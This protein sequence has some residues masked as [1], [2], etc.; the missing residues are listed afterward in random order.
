MGEKA[1]IKKVVVSDLFMDCY[2]HFNVYSQVERM[3]ELSERELYL[4]LI[5][6]LDKHD[7]ENT[8]VK[9][10]F[11]P[12]EKQIMEIF[13]V[14][15][16]VTHGGSI[17]IFAKNIEDKTKSIQESV[18]QMLKKEEFLGVKNLKYYKD[19]QIK[20]DEIKYN[21]LQFLYDQKKMNKKVIGYGAAAK[22]NTLLNYSGIKGDDLI[23]FVVDASPY[24]QG[25]LMPGSR[26]IVVAPESIEKEKPDFVIIFPWNLKEE[27]MNELAYIRNWGGKFVTFIPEIN[28]F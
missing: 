11:I 19:F 24:K 4:L 1:K 20:V 23:K 25:K 10:N 5:L 6:C 3:N 27:L 15:E 22:G 28:I 2:K 16:L 14:Q 8:V 9:H 13:D 17:R 18:N 26:I 12:F 21:F 7:D